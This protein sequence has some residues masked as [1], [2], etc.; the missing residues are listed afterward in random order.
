[1]RRSFLV[2]EML[3]TERLRLRL[4]RAEDFPAFAAM[5]ADPEVNRHIS[6]ADL[7]D[8]TVAFRALGWLIGHWHLRGYGPWLVEER[9][10]GALVGRVGGYYPLEWPAP[11]IAW[12]LGRAW[13]GRGLAQE[14]ASA[15]RVAVREHLRPERLVSVVATDNQPSRRLARRLGCIPAERLQIKGIDC[16]VFDHPI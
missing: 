1:M 14:A 11:E 6:G 15:A 5:L 9:A 13:W 16:I 7:A 8:P 2:P 12:T 10:S 3:E 4:P